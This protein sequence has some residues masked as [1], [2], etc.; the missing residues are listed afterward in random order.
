MLKTLKRF[1]EPDADPTGAPVFAHVCSGLRSGKADSYKAEGVA[2]KA[3][4]FDPAQEQEP[5]W[6]EGRTSE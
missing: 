3:P 6:P 4:T 5:D 1:D 2:H